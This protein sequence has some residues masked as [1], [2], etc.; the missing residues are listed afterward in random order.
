[1][2]R[3]TPDAVHTA[4]EYTLRQD[5]G[6]LIAALVA[7]T[8]DFELAEEC[9]QDAIE[10]ALKDWPKNGIP[11]SRRGW[12]LQVARRRAIDRIRRAKNLTEKAAQIAILEDTTP[13]DPH[14]IPDHRLRLIFTCCHPALA[15][16]TRV[17]LTLR[18][19][20]GLTTEEVARAFLDK[21]TAMGQRLSRARAKISKARIP[22]VIPDGPDLPAR[23]TSVLSVIY[24]VFNEGY[25]ATEGDAQIRVDL[26]EEA[27]FLARMMLGF[28]PEDTEVAGL[29]ALILLSHARRAARNATAQYVPLS[30]HNRS[31]WNKRL[32]GEGQEILQSA[33]RK[34]QVGPYQLQ[35]SI[36]AL[37]CE[38]AHAQETDWAQIAALYRL[39]AQ[40]N[41]SAVVHL[42]LAVALSY[43]EGPASALE[44]LL[45]LRG[46]LEDYQPYHAARADILM[47][48]GQ[49]GEAR[50]AYEQAL[51]LTQIESERVWLLE[52]Q[53]SLGTKK[54]G[55]ARSSALSPT[56]R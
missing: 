29:L 27:I 28:C 19:L 3:A 54:R 39:L 34:G 33:L 4:I 24:L 46:P 42:N 56:G 36:S 6:H 38:A 47:R 1:M 37:H 16:K 7:A 20:G 8:R 45:E 21:P 53:K 43:C 51:Q 55:R 18:T 23:I 32:I 11:K 14:D 35:A 50:A 25:A 26:C 5:R 9:L 2:I 48:V 44:C 41:P 15:E 31:L 13:T 52:R 10:V 30:E 40:M 22:F 49:V 12:L 17:A